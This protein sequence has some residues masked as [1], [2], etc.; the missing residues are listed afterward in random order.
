MI[1]INRKRALVDVN[2]D[3]LT[4][5]QMA[6][7][8]AAELSCEFGDWSVTE[9][10]Y[11]CD[12]CGDIVVVMPDEYCEVEPVR[13]NEMKDKTTFDRIGKRWRESVGKVKEY[14]IIEEDEI[15]KEF[16]PFLPFGIDYQECR[17]AE[18]L[19]QKLLT[20]YKGKTLEDVIKGKELNTKKGVCYHIENQDRINLKIINPEQARENILSDLKLIYGIGEVTERIL[21]EEGYKTIEDLMEHPRFASEA[22]KFLDIVDKCDVSK[23]SS[24]STLSFWVS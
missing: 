19:K 14:E 3:D 4:E 9:I 10:T 11:R 1:E 7:Y 13:I 22:N 23:I 21:K 15:D 17:K 6:D 5:G 8:M 24:I 16:T 12:K 18:R 20:K 2:F